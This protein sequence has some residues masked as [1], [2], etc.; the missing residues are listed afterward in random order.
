MSDN[1]PAGPMEGS[2]IYDTEELIF[3]SCSAPLLGVDGE[4]TDDGE[5]DFSGSVDATIRGHRAAWTCPECG[6]EHEE[7]H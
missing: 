1:Y 4:E 3:V 5:C 7:S 6:S 2:G